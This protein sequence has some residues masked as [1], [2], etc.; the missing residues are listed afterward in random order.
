MKTPLLIT[1]LALAPLAHAVASRFDADWKQ[2]R[3]L[4]M[5]S[6]AYEEALDAYYAS[7]DFDAARCDKGLQGE[8]SARLLLDFD[9]RGVLSIRSDATSEKLALCLSHHFAA[10]P[11]P[12]PPRLPLSLPYAFTRHDAGN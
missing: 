4:P 2:A 3:A 6:A 8:Q 7:D 11:P 5:P 10:N 12:T 9:A 1:L